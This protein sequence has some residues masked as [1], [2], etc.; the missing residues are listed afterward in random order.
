MYKSRRIALFGF[1]VWCRAL[2][3]FTTPAFAQIDLVGEWAPQFHEDNPERLAGPDL[4][5]FAGLPINDA[6]RMMADSWN[7][8]ILS[9]PGASMQATPRRL[10]AARSRRIADLEGSRSVFTTGHRHSHSHSVAGAGTLDLDGWP[11]ASG[12]IRAAHVA[13]LFD[14]RMA[15]PGSESHDHP[16]EEGMD[17]PQRQSPEA[18]RPS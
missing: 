12:R 5:D 4:G 8:D 15:R 9:I 18:I 16:L 10:L 14:W 6:A 1:F 2:A 13:G 7:A 17:P 11:S 3:F